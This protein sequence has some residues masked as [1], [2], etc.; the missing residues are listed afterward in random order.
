M[1]V[2]DGLE[3]FS[4][5]EQGETLATLLTQAED[6]LGGRADLKLEQALID[7]ADLFDVE[8]PEGEPTPLSAQADVLHG[9]EHPEDREVVDRRRGA[10]AAFQPRIAVRIEQI[11]AIG[12]QAQILV[13]DA[14]V[15]SPSEGEQSMPSAGPVLKG[16]LTTYG[17][18]PFQL[19][20][21]PTDGIGG[22][23]TGII[24]GQQPSLLGE[25]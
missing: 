21:E 17:R 16:L 5:G 12:R 25:Q 24:A 1:E 6:W 2:G 9:L 3:G 18:A 22:V 4:Q 15:K 20:D 8:G 23:I 11:A 14:A 13:R 19:L 7:V 10:F